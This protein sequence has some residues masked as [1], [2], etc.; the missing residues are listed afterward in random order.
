[1]E[2]DE[3]GGVCSTH[4]EMRNAYKVLVGKPEG[5]RPQEDIDVGGSIILK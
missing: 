2:V 3:M 5:K 1:V 4:G